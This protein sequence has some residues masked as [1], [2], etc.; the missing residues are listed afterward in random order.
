MWSPDLGIEVVLQ[1]SGCRGLVLAVCQYLYSS[2]Q[3]FVEYV[4]NNGNPGAAWFSREQLGPV[5]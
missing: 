4:D 2:T 5:L 1:L 3:Y